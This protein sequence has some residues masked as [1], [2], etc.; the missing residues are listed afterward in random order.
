[1][2]L[3]FSFY[4]LWQDKTKP[5]VIQVNAELGRRPVQTTEPQEGVDLTIPLILLFLSALSYLAFLNAP[6]LVEYYEKF[7]K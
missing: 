2:F 3:A 5:I 4:L 7:V 1:M 6:K